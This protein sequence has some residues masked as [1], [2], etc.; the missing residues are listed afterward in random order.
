MQV[1]KGLKTRDQNDEIETTIYETDT[2]A[3]TKTSVYETE[4][5]S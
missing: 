5:M 3:N 1:S 2:E 4:T